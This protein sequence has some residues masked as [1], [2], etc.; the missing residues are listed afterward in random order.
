MAFELFSKALNGI[1]RIEQYAQAVQIAESHLESAGIGEPLALGSARGRFDDRFAWEITTD[2]YDGVPTRTVR[3]I[4]LYQVRVTVSWRQG[5]GSQS[6][7]LTS[8]R[9]ALPRGARG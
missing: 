3:S 1:G 9:P 8:I 4:A 5:I 7:S 2:S 6:V